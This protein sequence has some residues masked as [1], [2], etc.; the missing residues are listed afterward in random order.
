M[1]LSLLLF[2]SILSRDCEEPWKLE[3]W[4][5]ARSTPPHAGAVLPVP[6]AS[7]AGVISDAARSTE[8]QP[9][10]ATDRKSASRILPPALAP[11]AVYRD[12]GSVSLELCA[13]PPSPTRPGPS[14]RLLFL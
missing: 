11:G 13:W 14:I 9:T 6:S 4:K 2:L 7:P 12:G 3:T 5:T 8:D 1:F 10:S